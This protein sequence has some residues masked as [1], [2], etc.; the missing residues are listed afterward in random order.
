[1][2]DED[3]NGESDGEVS[4]DEADTEAY[5]NDEGVEFNLDSESKSKPTLEEY[6]K[7]HVF[8]RSMIIIF[9][10]DA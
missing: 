1:M 10:F 2:K 7:K 5:Q 3:E 9:I 4:D 6:V 8:T